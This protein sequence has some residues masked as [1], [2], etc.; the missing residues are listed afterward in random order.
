MNAKELHKIME[1]TNATYLC[2]QRFEKSPVELSSSLDISTHRT[3]NISFAHSIQK[4]RDA[5]FSDMVIGDSLE[6]SND[7]VHVELSH[8]GNEGSI[9]FSSDGV[10]IISS[11]ALFHHDILQTIH[12][13]TDIERETI[14]H[15]EAITHRTEIISPRKIEHNFVQLS[16]NFC[17]EFQLSAPYVCGAMA[18]GIASVELVSAFSE[19]DMLSFFGAGG[20]SIVEIENAL[21][22]LSQLDGVWGSNLLHSPNEPEMED[23]LVDL[24]C[25][26]GVKLI[27][28]SAYMR[29]S[30]ALI[31][32][33][34]CGLYQE[35]GTVKCRHRIFAKV[36][37]PSVA[38]QFLEPPSAK[39]VQKLFSL[40]YISEQQARWA[41]KIPMC[42]ALTVEGDSGGHTDRRNAFSIF[43]VIAQL[44]EVSVKTYNHN[45][46]LGI[47]GGIGEP[48]AFKAA[49]S[50][51]ADYVLLGSIHQATVEAGTSS[52]VKEMLCKA[53]IDHFSYGVSPDM[54][55]QGAVVQVFSQG[56]MYAQRT[57]TLRN[58]YLKN[59]GISDLSSKE[60]TRVEKILGKPI[61]SI[62][63]ETQTYWQEKEPKLIARAKRDEK[64]KMSLIFRWYLGLSSRWAR[65]GFV[66]RKK[67]F[68]IWSGPALGSFNYWVQGT[69]LEEP[70]NRNAVVVAQTILEGVLSL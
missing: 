46:F 30:L 64:L 67:D 31:R 27:S 13:Y 69:P 23:K 10:E 7:S 66:K 48:R 56:T 43:P 1:W 47:A 21:Q 57:K 26:Y 11:F 28:A 45:V 24:Y 2:F 61:E 29:L 60:R 68:Q 50:L 3:T 14:P 18:G 4:Y 19:A 54:F 52:L 20:L 22:E 39:D 32:Y 40:G 6:L 17:M 70:K 35:N 15:V 33:R 41:E 37:H 5:I 58:I 49:L 25:K 8:N 51:G 55:E 34:I 38:K 36:S 53:Q 59:D 62:W 63:L 65:Q 12:E 42:D 44:R 16:P 9:T